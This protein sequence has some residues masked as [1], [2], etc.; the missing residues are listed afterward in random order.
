M[1]VAQLRVWSFDAQQTDAKLVDVTAT[2]RAIVYFA[3][4]TCANSNTVDVA[5]RIGFGVTT[6]PTITLNSL[7][8][9]PGILFKHSGIAK[10]G[11]AM[12]PIAAGMAV[13]GAANED[14]RLTCT[15][16][17]GGGLDVWLVYDVVDIVAEG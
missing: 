6:L 13:S 2:Q 8:G 16:P 12:A 3:G 4:V 11:G 5:A 9:T 14:I 7:T 10:G 15:V 17:T 1:Q